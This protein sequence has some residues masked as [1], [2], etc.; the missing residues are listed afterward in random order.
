MASSSDATGPAPEVDVVGMV[1]VPPSKPDELGPKAQESAANSRAA[2]SSPRQA[3][4]HHEGTLRVDE[5]PTG[6][7]WQAAAHLTTVTVGMGVLGLPAALARLRW[8]PGLF[9]MFLVPVVTF[10]TA[11]MLTQMHVAQKDA[12]T[13]SAAGRFNTYYRLCKRTLAYKYAKHV[14]EPFQFM[15]LFCYAVMYLITAGQN[16]QSMVETGCTDSCDVPRLLVFTSIMAGVQ[17]GVSTVP[18]YQAFWAASAVAVGCSFLYGLMVFALTLYAGKQ[19]NATYG[20][21]STANPVV[22]MLDAFSGI[23]A[24]ILAFGSHLI[25]PEVQATLKPDPCPRQTG[26][27][28]VQATWAYTWVLYMFTAITGYWAFGN[29]VQGNIFDSIQTVQ[30]TTAVMNTLAAARFF[31]VVHAVIGFHVLSLPA[32][33]ALE[34]YFGRQS[35]TLLKQERALHY[36]VRVAYIVAAWFFAIWLPF[37][38]RF[39]TLFGTLCLFPLALIMPPII[40][41]S[42]RGASMGL[43]TK[44]LCWTIVVLS[45]VVA[46]FCL[47]AGLRDMLSMT[48]AYYTFGDVPQDESGIK[49]GR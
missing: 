29:L 10:Y 19:P 3:D 30:G 40:Y 34:R 36:G 4:E 28:A 48:Y 7:W 11:Y 33:G 5:E 12:E 13:G 1:A 14:V 22:Q 16:F 38:G 39:L 23:L 25:L 32:Y 9:V 6:E 20:Y 15:M 49:I 43:A 17:L 26:L 41:M 35:Q 21:V 31:V 27:R 47:L 37:F 42:Y 44:I 24:F 2:G 18:K 45:T 46:V 8:G